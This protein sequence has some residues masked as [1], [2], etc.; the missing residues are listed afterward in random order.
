MMTDK[1]A[2]ILQ[3]IKERDRQTLKHW[4]PF[5]GPPDWDFAVLN[6][7]KMELEEGTDERPEVSN[8]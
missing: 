1:A 4:T 6:A 7:P 8:G 3:R 5:S 2:R